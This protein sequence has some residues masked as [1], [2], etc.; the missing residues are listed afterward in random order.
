MN[1][2]ALGRKIRFKFKFLSKFGFSEE[3]DESCGNGERV[4]SRAAR[5]DGAHHVWLRQCCSVGKVA[6]SVKLLNQ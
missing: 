2:V 6:Q 1:A 5:D 3:E 4:C